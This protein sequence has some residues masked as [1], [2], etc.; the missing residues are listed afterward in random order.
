[1][2]PTT[3]ATEAP[4]SAQA[5][6][7]GGLAV[8]VAILGL[9]AMA[10]ALLGPLG[11]GAI[12]YHVS[13]GASA[14]IRGSD[15]VSLLLVGPLCLFTAWLLWRRRPGAEQLALAPAAYGLYGYTQ[16]AISGDLGRYPGNS[17]DW[18]VLFWALIVACGAVLVLA[19]VRL[20]HAAQV[21]PRR[22]LERVTGWFLLVFAT[23]LTVG[24]HLPGL[25]A[26]W[27]DP[28]TSAEY[29]A[30]PVVFWVVKVMDLGY[31]VPLVA[32]VGVGLLSGRGWARR[33]MPP[34][35]GWCALMVTAVA[36]MAV[37]MVV[38]GAP[39]ASTAVTVGM[40]GAAAGAMTLAVT[41]YRPLLS[42]NNHPDGFAGAAQPQ[43]PLTTPR[44]A[45]EGALRIELED[46]ATRH[47]WVSSL[48]LVSGMV[49]Q[50]HFVGLVGDEVRYE[51]ATFAAPY[52]WGHLPLGRTM[53]PREQWAPGM[54]EALNALR[55]EVAAD[56][57]VPLG[58]GGQE[59][60]DCYRNAACSTAG[61]PAPG[62]SDQPHHGRPPA[63]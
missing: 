61:S 47:A 28:P 53:L 6:A 10:V 1:V 55:V 20:A 56:G 27:K 33:L 62:S 8:L 12:E 60:Q 63:G 37:M 5:S 2:T 18:F 41:G 46:A 32:T 48:G 16:L 29:L 58:R 52:S 36:G 59:W 51:S 49:Q 43:T 24:L 50:W 17:E 14:Q 54:R 11:L 44:N 7:P 13:A 23:L 57:W 22:R 35:A 40:C 19:G 31:L 21:P 42:N 15:A 30:D 25:L 4:A 45:A 39:G 38:T 34:V 3:T 9:G 26:A